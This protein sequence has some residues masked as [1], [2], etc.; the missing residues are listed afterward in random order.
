[1]KFAHRLADRLGQRH[2]AA[3]ARQRE[4]HRRLDGELQEAADDRSPGEHTPR[5]A[6]GRCC[7][8][9]SSSVADHRR[10]STPPARCRTAGTCRGCSG[11]RGTTPTPPATR[12][13]GRACGRDGSSARA[14]SP[15]KPG[16][17]SGMISGAGSTPS[18][19]STDDHQ[20]Q[21]REERPRRLCGR[22]ARR[23]CARSPA[24]TGMNEPDSAPFAEQ[25]LQQVGNAE[26][27]VERVGRLGPLAEEVPRRASSGRARRGGWRGC[28]PPPSCRPAEAA[29]RRGR[30]RP[31]ARLGRGS[32]DPCSPPATRTTPSRS[33]SASGPARARARRGRRWCGACG[34]RSPCTPGSD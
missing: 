9:K 27:R 23:P 18:S 30:Y 25:V 3:C 21:Q 20:H 22:F 15:V 33:R 16:A 12:R 29:R 4:G 7:P 26:R 13:R 6:R 14:S 8:P 24:W 31:L 32:A 28:R 1:M 5:A 19:T 2:R 34:R 10:R 17:I 11:R